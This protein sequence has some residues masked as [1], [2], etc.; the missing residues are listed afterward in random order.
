VNIETVFQYSRRELL[1]IVRVSRKRWC[2]RRYL[3]SVVLIALA[4]FPIWPLMLRGAFAGAGVAL[5]LFTELG[6]RR[7]ARVATKHKNNE[8]RTFTITDEAFTSRTGAVARSLVWAEMHSV[9]RK[10]D[11]WYLH[12]TED[13]FVLFPT[14]ALNDEQRTAFE[15]LL[16]NRGWGKLITASS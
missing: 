11:W 1:Y 4:L 13:Q 10:G 6:L 12:A 7:A 2:Q 14:R 16:V 8:P 3:V 5:A 9:R 15:K